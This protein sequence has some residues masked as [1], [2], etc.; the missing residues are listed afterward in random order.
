MR[1]LRNKH[2]GKIIS[3]DERLLEL[4]RY[5]VVEDSAS[6]TPAPEKEPEV[7]T[8]ETP[9]EVAIQQAARNLLKRKAKPSGGI[10]D[11]IG[12]SEEISIQLTRG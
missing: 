9:A 8:Q 6:P 10:Q 7:M 1:L 11:H 4:G 12:A 5:E 3:Y 2:T